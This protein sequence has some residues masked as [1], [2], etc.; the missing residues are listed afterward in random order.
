MKKNQILKLQQNYQDMD[1]YFID[2][3][4]MIQ[5]INENKELEKLIGQK[6]DINKSKIGVTDITFGTDIEYIK[7]LIK[8]K[9]LKNIILKIDNESNRL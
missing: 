4:V 8:N 6:F 3:N 1:N 9:E 5:L 2:A 7:Q